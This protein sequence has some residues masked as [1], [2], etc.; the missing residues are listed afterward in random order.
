MGLS[1]GTPV[2]RCCS[3]TAPG[4]RFAGVPTCREVDATDHTARNGESVYLVCRG[5]GGKELL[6]SQNTRI[7]LEEG[8]K[9][10]HMI[11]PASLKPRQRRVKPFLLE[12]RIWL[13]RL[14][15]PP[16]SPVAV[17]E[18]NSNVLL[19]DWGL[20]ATSLHFNYIFMRR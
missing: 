7:T 17:A 6:T 13:D 18:P 16:R 8:H 9:R 2:A 20:G 11:F 15:E 3:A 10:H 1:T 12:P 5:A 19:H 4:K 14:N